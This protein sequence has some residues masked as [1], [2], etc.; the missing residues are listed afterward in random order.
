ME[1]DEEENIFSSGDS[2]AAAKQRSKLFAILRM[3][4][5]DRPD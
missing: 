3:R 2:M 5:R 1:Y 4:P